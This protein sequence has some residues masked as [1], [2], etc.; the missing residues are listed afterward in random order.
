MNGLEVTL[1]ICDM[2][3]KTSKKIDEAVRNIC[4]SIYR[5][6]FE[7]TDEVQREIEA[8]LVQTIQEKWELQD[9]QKQ[10]K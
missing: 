3:K 5:A 8:R 4:I 2:D 10:K 9:K 1:R 6:A 7:I